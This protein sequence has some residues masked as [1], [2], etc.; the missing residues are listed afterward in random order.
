MYVAMA[1][2]KYVE[3]RSMAPG[4][5]PKK[6]QNRSKNSVLYLVVPLVVVDVD[7]WWI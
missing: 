3:V 6:E 1:L 7:R 2:P 4:S 5:D